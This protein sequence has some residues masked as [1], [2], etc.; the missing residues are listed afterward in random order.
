MQLV[1]ERTYRLR[2]GAV[3]A[4]QPAPLGPVPLRWDL[5]YGGT[6]RTD[7]DAIQRHAANPIGRGFA[8][9]PETLVG[10]RAPQILPADGSEEVSAGFGP[11]PAD[12]APRAARFG[13]L[14]DDDWARTRAPVWPRAA[15]SLRRATPLA[16]ST[17]IEV[18]GIRPEATWKFV[19]PRLV[20][21][22]RRL[23][24]RLVGSLVGST[25]SA[26]AEKRTCTSSWRCAIETSIAVQNQDPS[27]R[28]WS[29]S[30]NGRP[31]ASRTPL[32]APA[33]P[34]LAAADAWLSSSTALWTWAGSV[35]PPPGASWTSGP[36]PPTLDAIW[37][38]GR[39]GSKPRALNF[40]GADVPNAPTS[41]TA[42]RSGSRP[43]PGR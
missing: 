42:S 33:S 38:L 21:S 19:L 35:E 6:D 28:G 25:A 22:R 26:M 16:P 7:P 23:V 12:W 36:A 29:V 4:S 1:G 30:S 8:R 18:G 34:A 27:K 5:A 11:L 37:S 31:G 17:P 41:R 9:D 40:P 24:A 3:E 2:R 43:Q 14:D 15:P 32:V 20:R 10:T 39:A 13:T